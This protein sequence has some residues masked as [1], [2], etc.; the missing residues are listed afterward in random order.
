MN[1]SPI[2]NFGQP[3]VRKLATPPP[4]RTPGAPAASF[5]PAETFSRS[6][7]IEEYEL[8]RSG[9]RIAFDKTAKTVTV[10]GPEGETRTIKNAE[11]K[12]WLNEASS[13]SIA[14]FQRD[15]QVG[16]LAEHIY[17]D[18]RVG[19]E[20]KIPG[21][22]E[23]GNG[24][25]P[26]YVKVDTDGHVSAFTSQLCETWGGAMETQR[27]SQEVQS[28]GAGGFSVVAPEG[29]YFLTPHVGLG[30]IR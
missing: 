21:A 29:V 17:A 18:G 14:I 1:F 19:I 16:F 25:H 30:S 10:A 5:Q 9:T 26:V 6:T 28:D 2:Q 11:V 4:V 24:A 8:P 13:P 12:D 20:S 15:D 27:R 22:S 3:A 23:S 7:Q